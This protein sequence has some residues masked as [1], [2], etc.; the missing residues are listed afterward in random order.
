LRSRPANPGPVD[1]LTFEACREALSSAIATVQH[2]NSPGDPQLKAKL[3]LLV[4]RHAE[5]GESDPMRLRTRALAT[6]FLESSS[7]DSAPEG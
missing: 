5:K 1:E 2:W 6:Y 7:K 4:I 3:A